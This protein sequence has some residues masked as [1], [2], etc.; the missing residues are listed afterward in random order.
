MGA[1]YFERGLVISRYNQIL[2][3]TSRYNHE[4]YFEDPGT[5]EKITILESQ[6]WGDFHA[7]RIKIV[8]AFSSPK[9]LDFIDPQTSCDTRTLADFDEKNQLP[10]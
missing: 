4:I 7:K 2:E 6:F 10:G 3:Y 8:N 1:F 9:E 5:G